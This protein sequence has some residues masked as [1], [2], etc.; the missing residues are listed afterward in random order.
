MNITVWY[1]DYRVS[2][3]T[4]LI[5]I[6]IN[7][8]RENSTTLSKRSSSCKM[9]HS[10]TEENAPRAY[11]KMSVKSRQG[12]QM[13]IQELAFYPAEDLWHRLDIIVALPM[14][15]CNDTG[16]P[17]MWHM[18]CVLILHLCGVWWTYNAIGVYCSQLCHAIS[19]DMKWDSDFMFVYLK[20]PLVSISMLVLFGLSLMF[21]TR[22]GGGSVLNA[23][24]S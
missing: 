8:G 20:S 7:L 24:S 1:E 19:Y 5:T 13:T 16:S 15:T 22:T 11:S 14:L 6:E 4:D 23:A 17:L 10:K 18:E 21:L 3:V 2:K 12:G 9:K